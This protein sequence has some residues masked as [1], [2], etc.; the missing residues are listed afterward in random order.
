MG[1]V[2]L[3]WSMHPQI[4]LRQIL[5]PNWHWILQS[6]SEI[7][8]SGVKTFVNGVAATFAVGEKQTHFPSRQVGRPISHLL[9]QSVLV[10]HA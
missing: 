7:H 2:Y 5:W 1:G 3:G 10:V 6:Q 9:A 8:F 4:F